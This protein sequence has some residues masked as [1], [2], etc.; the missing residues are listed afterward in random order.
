M[1]FYSITVYSGCQNKNLRW[2][3]LP[4]GIRPGKLFFKSPFSKNQ[5]FICPLGNEPPFFTMMKGAKNCAPRDLL[6]IY[7]H[8]IIY[9]CEPF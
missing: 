3:G 6:S 2:R 5:S 9:P 8:L 4:A 1:N 7:M